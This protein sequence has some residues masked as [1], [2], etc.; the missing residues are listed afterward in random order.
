VTAATFEPPLWPIKV[1]SFS[2]TTKKRIEERK[3]MKQSLLAVA[4]ASALA[5]PGFA[6]A[7][8]T[9]AGTNVQVYG[10]FDMAV[11]Q[12]RYSGAT[13]GTVGNL[14]KWH[15]HNGA[16]N[17]LGFR[18]T[19]SLGGGLSA[20]FQ[21]ESQVFLDGR[22][23]NASGPATNASVGGRPTFMG[24][25]AP[26][27]E[28]SVGYQESVYKDVYAA[29]WQVGPTQPHFGIIMGNG[30]TTG[31]IPA[32][33][34]GTT[35]ATCTGGQ[36][37]GIGTAGITAVATGVPSASTAPAAGAGTPLCGTEAVG[38]GTSFNRTMS[39]SIMF[40]SPVFA[41]SAT[42]ATWRLAS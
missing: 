7:Q 20:F 21:V 2:G 16:P 33:T 30:N 23:D 36:A 29:T 14:N 28:V 6:M 37:T 12:D 41:G 8:A 5:A 3:Q 22:V 19:E 34:A 32:P 4:V 42:A 17:R 26:W 13:A 1:P 39:D 40:R 24:L 11:R 25:R 38:N 31:Q 15:M 35:A 18:G 9:T 27:G 10:L